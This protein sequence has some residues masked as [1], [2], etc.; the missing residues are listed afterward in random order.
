ML[1]PVD[2]L[3][4]SIRRKTC[5]KFSHFP[6]WEGAWDDA[7]PDKGFSKF[8]NNSKGLK[9][10]VAVNSSCA[11]ILIPQKCVIH[12]Y[13]AM[14]TAN[15]THDRLSNFFFFNIIL[16]FCFSNF[17][18]NDVIIIRKWYLINVSLFPFALKKQNVKKHRYS[19]T[20][21]KVKPK[22]FNR[23]HP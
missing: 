1:S 2:L 14:E 3:K 18:S 5:L 10:P 21:G 9:H 23:L 8:W 11:E 17:C 12:F 20:V 4:E 6:G 19:S 7:I 22:L 15:F 13:V 16:F